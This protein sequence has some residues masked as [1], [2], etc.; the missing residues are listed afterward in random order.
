M[1]TDERLW[2]RT[3]DRAAMKDD[4]VQAF[5]DRFPGFHL[6]GETQ[7]LRQRRMVTLAS[8][9][10]RRALLKIQRTDSV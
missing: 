2:A 1:V 7:Q 8:N 4:T 3:A 10:L 5:G 9:V 6:I